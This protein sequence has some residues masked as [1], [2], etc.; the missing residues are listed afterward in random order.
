M[1]ELSRRPHVTLQCRVTVIGVDVGICGLSAG[2]SACQITLC[3][4]GLCGITACL[5]AEVAPLCVWG[6]WEGCSPD[7]CVISREAVGL[8]HGAVTTKP[9]L[10]TCRTHIAAFSSPSHFLFKLMFKFGRGSVG[11]L[12]FCLEIL[13]PGL[14]SV[15]SVLT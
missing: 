5:E 12:T 6:G 8:W 15:R 3:L 1:K 7:G 2:I 9:T 4:R 13:D 11:P 10:C 14:V